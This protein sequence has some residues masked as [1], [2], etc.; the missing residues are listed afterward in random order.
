MTEK[1]SMLPIGTPVQIEVDT[2]DQKFNSFVVGI[3]PDEFLILKTPV[4]SHLF[5]A[6]TNLFIGNRVVVRF[7]MKGTIIGFKSSLIESV[8]N[9]TKLIFIQ[10]PSEIFHHELRAKKRIECNLPLK[11]VF[12]GKTYPGLLLDMNDQGCKFSMSAS[13]VPSGF[14]SVS[15]D[16]VV[17]F[18]MPGVEKELEILGIPKHIKNDEKKVYVGIQFNE[19]TSEV[20]EIIS[21]YLASFEAIGNPS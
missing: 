12:E 1:L 13:R 9:P 4:S 8:S 18:F 16:I 5:S 10:Y 2:A 6:R 11:A 19:L 3:L 20:T 15:G 14:N 7:I 21:R 17:K